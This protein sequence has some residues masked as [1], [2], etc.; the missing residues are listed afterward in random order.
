MKTIEI[1]TGRKYKVLLGN[2]IIDSVGELIKQANLSGK[3]CVITDKNVDA[4][5]SNRLIKNLTNSGYEVYKQV[6]EGGE[7][8]KTG[9]EFLRICEFLAEKSFTRTDTVLALGGGIVGDL[10]G[11]IASAF[12]RG[13]KFVQVPTTLLSLV[14]SSVGGKTA[15]NLSYGKNLVG[16]FYQP[17]LVIG[18]LDTLKTLPDEEFSCGMAEV[19]KYATVFDKSLFELLERNRKEDLE[20]VVRR[21]ICL[22]KSVV[23]V[24]EFDNGQR[25]LLNFGHTLGHSI[26]QASGFII[27]HGIAVGIGMVEI[28]K[29]SVKAGYCDKSILDRISNLLLLNG[30]RID[31]PYSI[32]ELFETTLVDKKRK[33]KSIS[34]VVCKG[35]GACEVE[36]MSIGKWKEFVLG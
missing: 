2:G 25:Q 26:E 27:S 10:T 19:I 24:D 7:N 28:V 11:F 8:S 1:N 15:I 32:K 29:A 13:I 21:C 33:G 3:I 30:L 6:V 18:D 20:E 22:K 23:E 35:I 9:H 16:A 36:E 17:N 34:P 12:A 5:Y 4:L 31:C 14:D